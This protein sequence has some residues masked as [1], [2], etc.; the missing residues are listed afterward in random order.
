MAE[1]EHNEL[2]IFD[3]TNHNIKHYRHKFSTKVSVQVNLEYFIDSHLLC[4]REHEDCNR[5]KLSYFT[6]PF[7]DYE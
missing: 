2:S 4:I 3:L 5:L 7:K 1:V 6:Y